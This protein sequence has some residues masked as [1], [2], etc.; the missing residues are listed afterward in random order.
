MN[1]KN[2][3]KSSAILFVGELLTKILGFVYLSPLSQIDDG[4]GAIQGYL[5]TPYSF[6]ITFSVMGITNVMMYKLGPVV[7]DKD[8]YKRHFLDGAYYVLI[9]SVV[10]TGFLLLTAGPMMESTTPKG[11]AE[12]PDLVLSLRLIAISILFF[13]FNTLVRAVML[14]KNY[15]TVI[16]ITYIT[17]Q[18]VKLII[19]LG[20]CYYFISVKGQDV[21]V[22]SYVTAW[23]VIISVA[24]TTLILI[25]YAIKIKLFDFMDGAKYKWR[26]SSF[27]TI[28]TLG[29]VYFVNNIFINGFSQIDLVMF[30]TG[31]ERLGYGIDEITSLTGAYFTWAWKVIMLVVTLGTVFL[32]IMIQQMTRSHSMEEK[33]VEMKN[34][35][36]FML[37]YSLLAT[38]FLIT[39]GS[40]F[41]TIFYPGKEGAEIMIAQ[42]LIIAPVMIRMLLSVF[43]ITVGKR[44]VVLQSTLL[45]FVAKIVLNPIFFFFFEINGFILSS[46]VA[47]SLSV[48]YMLIYDRDVFKFTKKEYRGKIRLTIRMT[49]VFLISAVFSFVIHKLGVSP[50]TS[51]MLISVQ[52]LLVFAAFNIR[53]IKRLKRML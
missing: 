41:Y 8:Q 1:K 37:L 34:V 35:L 23:S 39:A 9:T 16:S 24:T 48:A 19:L 6:F 53:A 31:L 30:S 15:V 46:V 7:D 52:I 42:S 47:T 5:M 18:L 40:D 11:I 43:A 28:F 44:R 32:T 29:A 22:S 3:L 49:L 20:G 10:I 26:P 38:I 25:G 14:S 50:F 45:V 2:F 17:E 51:F 21:I 27:K 36:D 12:L 13:G 33:V 4:I